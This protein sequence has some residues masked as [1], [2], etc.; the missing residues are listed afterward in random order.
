MLTICT[1]FGA[2]EELVEPPELELL[3]LSLPPHAAMSTL[4]PL[5]AANPAAPLPTKPRRVSAA[6]SHA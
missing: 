2:L 4:L 6:F 3:E 1:S 5:T